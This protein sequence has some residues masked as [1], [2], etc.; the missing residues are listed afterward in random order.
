MSTLTEIVD[1]LADRLKTIAA[2]DN[3]VLT[4]VRRP[5]DFPAA[6]I[7]PPVIPDYGLA[8]D[9]EG[10]DF[11]IPVDLVVG[12]AEA[13]QQTSLWPFLDWSGTSSVYAAIQADRTLGGLDVDA[14]AIGLDTNQTGF[15]AFGDG[16]TAY[17]VRLNV[18][19]IA[20]P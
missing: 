13:E 10:G 6:I 9:G 7:L 1:G 12:A 19:I 18:G 3:N 14:H 8:L 15:R 2:F 4:V 11:V 16:S 17:G 5:A 20:S